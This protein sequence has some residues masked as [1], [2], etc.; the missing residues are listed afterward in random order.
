MEGILQL[1]TVAL[2][3]VFVLFLTYYTTR[4]IGNYQKTQNINSNIK[5]LDAVRLNQTQYIQLVEIG[6]LIYILG[7]S[8][9]N[10]CLL[11]TCSPEMLRD[12]AEGESPAAG[13]NIKES[14]MALLEKA[15]K[16]SPKD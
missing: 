12:F 11:G 3:F 8:K 2:I 5:L 9:D 15:K 16:N 14:F 1:L 10:I 4:W 13:M 7:I 6:N